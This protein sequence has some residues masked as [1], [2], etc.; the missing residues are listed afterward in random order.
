[1]SNE[2][3]VETDKNSKE[4]LMTLD[5]ETIVNRTIK[6]EA[7]LQSMRNTK[8]D[9]PKGEDLKPEPEV[10][11]ATQDFDTL[12][13]ERKFFENN[14]DFVESKDAILGYTSKWISYNEAMML[15]ERNDPTYLAREKTKQANFTSWD[16][17][18]N[19]KTSY[20]AE[21]LMEL[22]QGQYNKVM[23]LEQAGK[24][25]IT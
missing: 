1:M 3:A 19:D 9:E 6:A 22:P 18:S 20:T 10:N 11:T 21:E 4:Y 7:K 23:E 13:E 14:P 5:S 24:V 12:Y 8:E 15:V 2:V 17:P 16:L 25:K